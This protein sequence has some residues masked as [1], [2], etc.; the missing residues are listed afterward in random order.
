M[1]CA[2]NLKNMQPLV[3][4]FVLRSLEI[5]K[6][7]T[8]A[9][10]LIILVDM[11]PCNLISFLHHYFCKFW[12]SYLLNISKVANYRLVKICEQIVRN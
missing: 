5:R 3:I 6:Y 1:K 4:F 11:H 2:I 8:R 10:G 7:I 12:P 9:Y